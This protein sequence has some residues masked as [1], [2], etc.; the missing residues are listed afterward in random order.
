MTKTIDGV[1]YP[2]DLKSI[3]RD[4]KLA[5]A[6]G[7]YLKKSGLFEDLLFILSKDSNQRLYATFI[8]PNARLTVNIS[9]SERQEVMD[10]AADVAA[11]RIGWNDPSMTKAINDVKG[12]V[13]RLIEDD[14]L[15]GSS[16]FYASDAFR[17]MHKPRVVEQAPDINAAIAEVT[18]KLDKKKLKVLGYENI[19]EKNLLIYV[20]QMAAYFLIGDAKKAKA[21]YDKIQ[22]IEP[23]NSLGAK[24]PFAGME[25]HLKTT[26]VLPN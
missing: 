3:L 6:L 8:D 22:R 10:L 20:Q 25:K 11:G 19:K 24:V 26:K 17:K 15:D 5:N 18:K 7:E 13:M 1:S 9:S 16:G 12:K 21:A 4:R 2:T 14:R 23:A